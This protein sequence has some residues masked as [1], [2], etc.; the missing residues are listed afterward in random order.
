MVSGDRNEDI[1]QTGE[2]AAWFLMSCAGIAA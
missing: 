1:D 2:C